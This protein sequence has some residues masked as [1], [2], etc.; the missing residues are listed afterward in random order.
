MT[1]PIIFAAGVIVMCLVAWRQGRAEE[2]EA[3][4]QA[5][6]DRMIRALRRMDE[7]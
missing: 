4:R 1:I 2:R 6:R 7:R 3:E 5:D